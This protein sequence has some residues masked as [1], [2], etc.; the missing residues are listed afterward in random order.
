M[1]ALAWVED[2]G[3]R[4]AAG[5]KG[6]TGDCVVRAVAIATGLPYRQ[7]Y[8][9][10]F[11]MQRQRRPRK[12]ERGSNRSPRDGVFKDTTKKYLAELGW[13]WTPTMGIGTGTRVHLAHGELP[14]G[15]L[16]VQCSKHVVAVID[17]VARDT[18]DPSR[19]G[20]RAVYGFWSPEPIE[21][22]IDCRPTMRCK[23]HVL[24]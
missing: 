7:V 4:E 8:D 6:K 22:C 24:P 12:N 15:R 11:E 17:G 18:Y 13:S 14:M 5:F 9:E 10:L 1:T 19:D 23:E 3:G 2:D 21:W 20:T 16:V